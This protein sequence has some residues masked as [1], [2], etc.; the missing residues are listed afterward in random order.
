LAA[1][2]VPSVL[3]AKSARSDKHFT[4]DEIAYLD[5]AVI[6]VIL[7]TSPWF[8]HLARPLLLLLIRPVVEELPFRSPTALVPGRALS[9]NWLEFMPGTSV[10][11]RSGSN[12]SG[13]YVVWPVS[14]ASLSE[15]GA[16]YPV[17]F[18]CNVP[19]NS[20]TKVQFHGIAA[21]WKPDATLPALTMSS[22]SE[23]VNAWSAAGSQLKIV[24]P[25]QYIAAAPE[26]LGGFRARG[27][28]TFVVSGL[29]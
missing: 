23:M 21:G 27:G 24:L 13:K 6:R 15:L 16:P 3:S 19:P 29:S 22:L 8:P 14:W 1:F 26:L 20:I 5:F 7:G 28:T 9:F 11:P 10:D 18:P 2:S 12:F 17:N 4:A 25:D